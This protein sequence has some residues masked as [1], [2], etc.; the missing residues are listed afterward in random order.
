MW[1]WFSVLTLLCK[2]SSVRLSLS[3]LPKFSILDASIEHFRQYS[4]G[5]WSERQ[6]LALRLWF[7]YIIKRVTGFD[8]YF[9]NIGFSKISF[10]AVYEPGVKC[11]S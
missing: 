3:R 10:E 8:S 7:S 4:D 6:R 9:K 1:D 5:F 2:P 11:K